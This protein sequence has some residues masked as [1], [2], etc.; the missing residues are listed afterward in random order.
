[1]IHP[2]TSFWYLAGYTG[3]PIRVPERV[4]WR[5]APAQ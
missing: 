5:A 4:H 3:V 2:P 1:M